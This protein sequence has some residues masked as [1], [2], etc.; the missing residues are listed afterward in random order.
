MKNLQEDKARDH[1]QKNQCKPSNDLNQN[2]SS[3]LT[4]LESNRDQQDPKTE[5]KVCHNIYK[6]EKTQGDT[7]SP[8]TET[9]S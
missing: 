1:L 7:R 6:A 2:Q 9:K 8:P 3:K 5:A 4:G